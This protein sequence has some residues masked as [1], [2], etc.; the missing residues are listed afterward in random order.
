MG[1]GKARPTARGPGTLASSQEAASLASQSLDVGRWD[2]QPPFGS[3]ASR[4]PLASV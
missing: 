1:A 3:D 4:V 2:R